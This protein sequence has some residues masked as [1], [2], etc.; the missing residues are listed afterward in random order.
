MSSLGL[1]A[2]C[3]GTGFSK[4]PRHSPQAQQLASVWYPKLQSRLEA[5]YSL[6]GA[7][8]L[9]LNRGIF[10][11]AVEQAIAVERPERLRIDNYSVMGELILSLRYE[12]GQLHLS[13]ARL[14]EEKTW[15][16]P[17]AFLSERLGLQLTMND[18]I[19]F[20][21][22]GFALEAPEAYLGSQQG[23]KVILY[24]EVSRIELDTVTSQVLRVIGRGQ[25]R[26]SYEVRY[27][28]YR[29]V[30]GLMFPHAIEVR[31]KNPNMGLNIEYQNLVL[32]AEIADARFAPTAA[33]TE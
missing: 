26:S 25:Q 11:R 24:G 22:G 1:V 23:N 2:S 30:D 9:R 28:D 10:S 27:Q 33:E 8:K 15:L 4:R 5:I 32:N 21:L 31:L 14:P 19:D 17:E 12:Q 20:L 13:G 6:K 18:L 16:D 3:A 7:A 29:E